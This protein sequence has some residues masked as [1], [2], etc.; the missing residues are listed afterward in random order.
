MRSRDRYVL[1]MREGQFYFKSNN[2]VLR[3]SRQNI[4]TGSCGGGEGLKLDFGDLA[5]NS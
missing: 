3:N 5:L 2:D 1:K 4:F